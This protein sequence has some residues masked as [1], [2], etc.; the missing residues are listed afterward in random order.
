MIDNYKDKGSTNAKQKSMRYD[1]FAT[2]QIDCTKLSHGLTLMFII[3]S[4]RPC[5]TSCS[6]KV[7]HYKYP[8][9]IDMFLYNVSVSFRIFI[10]YLLQISQ[11][12][13][14]YSFITF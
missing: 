8:R 5:F 9:I 1:Y 7:L 4:I 11:D 3:I 10:E 2:M 13:R 14:H 6:H 12:D